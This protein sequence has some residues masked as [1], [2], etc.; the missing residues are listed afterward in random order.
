MFLDEAKQKHILF[1][2]HDEEAQKGIESLNFAGRILPSDDDYLHINDVNF[3]GAK[4]NMFTKHFVKQDIK[5]GGDGSLTK[6]LTISYKNP[7]PPSNCN[8]EAGQLCL[9]GI[10]R[11]WL[12]VYVP[13]GST[14]VEFTGSE[15]ET[16]VYDE[17][18]RTVFEGFLTVKPQGAAEVRL[19]YK[20]PGVVKKENYKLYIQKQ[21]GTDDRQYS[22]FKDGKEIDKF[23]LTTDRE[24]QIKL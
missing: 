5:V 7:A 12:R 19:V 22:I 10:L 21:A 20:L 17:L 3:A 14:L 6:T 18:G 2:F 24:V 9:N 23:S 8:L 13:I 15:K 16:V 11:N 1:Y 4:S